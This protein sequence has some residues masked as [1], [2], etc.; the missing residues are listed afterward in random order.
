[1]GRT[2]GE[3][4]GYQREVF[5]LDSQAGQTQ[6]SD[7]GGGFPETTPDHQPGGAVRGGFVSESKVGLEV[8]DER[9]QDTRGSW[10]TD[11][12]KQRRRA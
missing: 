11:A 4:C 7:F 9:A 8:K 5:L 10:R 12:G 6:T 3:A 1:M 2:N